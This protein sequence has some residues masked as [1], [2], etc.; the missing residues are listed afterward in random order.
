MGGK[1]NESAN[2]LIWCRVA[3]ESE[4][5]LLRRTNGSRQEAALEDLLNL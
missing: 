5:W 3:G 4:E 1:L 2:S